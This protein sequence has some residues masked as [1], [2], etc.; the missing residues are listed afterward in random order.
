MTEAISRLYRRFGEI[1]TRERSPVYSDISLRVAEDPEILAF[2]AT[3]TPAK[4]QPNLL[5]GAVQY[6]CGPIPDWASF[7]RWFTERTGEIRDVMLARTTQTNEP[8]RCA[9]LLPALASLPQPLALLEVGAS[10]GLCLLPDRYGYDYGRA[11][12]PG[13]LMLPC[14]VDHAT[15]L[16]SRVP[17]IA[18]RAGLDLNPLDVADP[19]DCAWLEALIWPGE[20][21]RIP[22]LRA[23]LEIARR[24]PPPVHRG[25]LRADFLA[26]AAKAPRDATLVV[27]H[28][29][30]MMYVRDRSDRDAFAAAVAESGAVWLSNEALPVTPG[31]PAEH[32]VVVSRDGFVL[33]RDRAPIALTDPHGTWVEWL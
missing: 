16:P 20:E 27:F 30:V 2:L 5:Y 3:L 8:A 24:D 12:I 31:F 29:A 32:E 17:E 28:T 11:L 25:D 33:T 7:R 23:A 1:D 26:L 18:W 4:Y 14:K 21:E 6:L 15:P 9:T 19:D 22:R 13:E 10:A